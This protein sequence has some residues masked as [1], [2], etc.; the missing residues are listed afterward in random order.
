MVPSEWII[1]YQMYCKG[2]TQNF[3]P[4]INF[5]LLRTT[6][7]AIRAGLETP[8]NYFGV[9]CN[10]AEYLF[11]R[12]STVGNPIERKWQNIYLPPYTPDQTITREQSNFLNKAALA[13]NQPIHCNYKWVN[14]T[15]VLCKQGAVNDAQ[16]LTA[17]LNAKQL[18]FWFTRQPC[19]AFI[20]KFKTG[21]V[22]DPFPKRMMN[23][24]YE[25]YD[26]TAFWEQFFTFKHKHRQDLLQYIAYRFDASCQ[27][28]YPLRKAVEKGH[29]DTVIWLLKRE[30]VDGANRKAW[31]IAIS[32][33]KTAGRRRI[34][35]MLN[36]WQPAGPSAPPAY[37]ATLD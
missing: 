31:E 27:N 33:E 28:N 9:H 21:C 7:G 30:E 5:D 10:T 37:E 6:N 20:D 35:S 8:Q 15:L 34:L 24:M 32:A 23:W 13:S 4:P 16:A 29:V 14:Q 3:P 26:P 36:D 17:N 25:N 18:K 2:Q 1:D 19:Q 22:K 11:E 12:Y